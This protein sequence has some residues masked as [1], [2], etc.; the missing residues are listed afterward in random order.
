MNGTN[1]I[2]V[3]IP[4]LNIHLDGIGNMTEGEI[5]ETMIVFGPGIRSADGVMPWD[6]I[7]IT[8]DPTHPLIGEI[9]KAHSPGC[10]PKSYNPINTWWWTNSSTIRHTW[11]GAEDQYAPCASN[12]PADEINGTVIPYPTYQKPYKTCLKR[13]ADNSSDILTI[14]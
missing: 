13:T 12:G 10:G 14:C 11:N 9:N 6:L 8:Y 3:R 4:A 5:Y 2:R 1:S 7:C